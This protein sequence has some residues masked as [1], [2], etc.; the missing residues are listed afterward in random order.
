VTSLRLAIR[1]FSGLL[2]KKL[3]S[4]TDFER[5]GT[6]IDRIPAMWTRVWLWADVSLRCF[7]ME[8]SDDG[9]RIVTQRIRPLLEKLRTE[10][11]FEWGRATIAAA[12]ALYEANSAVAIEW[13]SK[14]P[15][16]LRDS[17]F[18][19]LLKFKV[20]RV[21][22]WEPY[23]E[24]SDSPH[25]ELDITE[26]KEI[27][28][29]VL[30]LDSDALV[31]R[32]I[33]AVARS[34]ARRHGYRGLSE[35]QK[36]EL[37]HAIRE[38]CA[39][40]FPNPR[41]I[42]HDGFAIVGEAQ[43]LRL[44]REKNANWSPLIER[45]RAIQNISDRAYVLTCIAEWMHNGLIR[46]KEAL[47]R[48]AKEVAKD[49]PSSYDRVGRLRTIA[50]IAQDVDTSFARVVLID[51]MHIIKDDNSDEAA[52]SRRAL[53]D[54]AYRID[55]DLATSLASS[56]DNDEARRSAREQIE[57]QA[58]KKRLADPTEDIKVKEAVDPK[59]YGRAAWDL[60]GQLNG[61]RIEP[62]D[63]AQTLTFIEAAARQPFDVSFSMLSWI[64]Q[65]A[66]AKR[67]S[68]DEA[69][70]LFRDV[71]EGTMGATEIAAALIRRATGKSIAWGRSF[72]RSDK[73]SIIISAEERQKGIEYLRVWLRNNA[74]EYLKICDP[75]FGPKDMEVLQLV[76]S[77]APGLTVTIVTSGRQQ[78]QEKVEW[79]FD[80]YYLRYWH[81]HFSDQEPP[82]TEIVV[83]GGKSEDLPIHDRWWLS[84]GCG[85]RFG[86]SFSGVGKSRDSEISELTHEEIEDRL[87]LTDAYTTRQKREHLGEK[88]SYQFFEL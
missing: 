78:R 69:R 35:Q 9:K 60:L 49:I 71:F 10:A 42:K 29:L 83:V 14:L 68:A 56:L 79:P 3:E 82:K 17:A 41:Y 38:V 24:R 36:N 86:S 45:G 84:K 40:K 16:H 72:Q 15:I 59:E 13:L 55:P 62:R 23:R 87:I 5:I 88:M 53:V 43:A 67:A 63:V 46:E 26:S 33:E 66:I 57:Y 7:G 11:Q 34:A 28:G 20:T 52:E 65:N 76:I 51:A 1:A 61:G 4:A 31:S 12:P 30:H 80:E 54:E 70:R 75:Y 19:N 81:K 85:L 44:I 39:K 64:I 37:A 74:R 27:L 25:H 47:L 48:E 32:Y 6:Q 22:P 58:L 73:N 21:T 77:E 8:R 2:P 50:S 18:D